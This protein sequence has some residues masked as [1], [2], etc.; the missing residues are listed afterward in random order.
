[1]HTENNGY[2]TT[3]ASE[4]PVYHKPPPSYGFSN[5]AVFQPYGQSLPPPISSV[6][7]QCA[8]NPNTIYMQPQPMSAFA[9]YGLPSGT[10]HINDYMAWS[11]FNIFCCGLVFGLIGAMLSSQV[12]QRKMAG[13]AAGAQSLSTVTAI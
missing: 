6:S 13:D 1:M 8:V 3:E 12:Q 5:T 7:V 2:N 11:I 4:P 9:V 10:A